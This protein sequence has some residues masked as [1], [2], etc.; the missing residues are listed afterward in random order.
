MKNIQNAYICAENENDPNT[1]VIININIYDESAS[2][3]NLSPNEYSYFTKTYLTSY[4]NNLKTAGMTYKYIDYQGVSALEY[5]F[6]QEDIPTKAIVFLKNKKSYLVQVATRKNLQS[7][8]N[9]VKF[10]FELL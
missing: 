10:S 6:Y 5:D 7:K 9:M 4:A 2:F 8:F 1:G 3:V